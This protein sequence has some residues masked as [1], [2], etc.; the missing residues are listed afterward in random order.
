M[1][2]AAAAATIP[3]PYE[4]A[5]WRGFR[6]SAVSYTLDDNSPKQFSVA[7]PL[8]DARGLPATFFCIVGNLSASQW[9]TIENASAKGHEIGSHT[10]THPDLTKKTDDQVTG[11]LLGAKE[12]IESHTGKKCVSLA[13][14]YCTVPKRSITTQFHSFARSC[15]GSLVPA[16]PTDFLSVGALGPDSGMDAASDTVA[17]S[18]RW[19][20][21][22]I[23]GIDDDPAC[24]PISSQMLKANLDYVAGNPDKWWVETFGNVCRY[25][26][27]REAAVLT[28]VSEDDSVI[29]LRLADELDD[30]VFNYPLTLR[31]PLP[32]SWATATITQNGAPVPSRM[33][34]GKLVFDVVP[35]GGDIVLTKGAL[36]PT[37]GGGNSGAA[38]LINVSI[39][40]TAGSGSNTLI[41]GFVLSGT[42]T[43]PMVLR[44]VGPGLAEFNVADPLVD[45]SIILYNTQG[46]SLDRNDNWGGATALST[47]FTSVGAFRLPPSSKDAAMISWLSATPYTMH[48]NTSNATSGTALAEVYDADTSSTNLHLVNI[49]G[50]GAV[51][52]SSNL[53]AGF[54]VGGSG[55]MNVLVRAVGPTLSDFNVTGVLSNPKVTI[56]DAKGAELMSND[57][58]GGLTTLSSTFAQVGAFKLPATSKDAAIEMTLSPGPYTAVVSGTNGATGVA[59]VEVYGVE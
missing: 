1:T 38:H 15:N 14:P 35:N 4:L 48:V 25:I 11:E 3:A 56:Y 36:A 6:A 31:R 44:G 45:P 21:W 42:G 7:Q 18:G 10:L 30:A 51:N 8:F 2:C 17:S 41:A 40:A 52:A 19:L 23:H 33:V 28:V 26:R 22:L 57:D 27:E 12:L 55:T 16:T 53:I 24:C 32:S 29:T 13:Y 49:S 47:A 43:K 37:G 20:V 46:T 59:L 39:R 54:V 50:R 34:D 58:W 5:T 9:A